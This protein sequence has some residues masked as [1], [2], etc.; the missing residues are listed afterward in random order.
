MKNKIII[1]LSNGTELVAELNNCDRKHPEIAICIQKEGIAI[2]D[3]CIVRPA[4]DTKD[5]EVTVECL[6]WGDECLEDY[7]DRFIIPPYEENE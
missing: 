5:N 2:Q 4:D 1:S 6:V 3:I 7:T